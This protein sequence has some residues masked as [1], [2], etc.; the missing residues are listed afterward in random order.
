MLGANGSSICDVICRRL[1]FVLN[2][3]HSPQLLLV[4]FARMCNDLLQMVIPMSA[5]VLK[6]PYSKQSFVHLLCGGLSHAWQSTPMP[7]HEACL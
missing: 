5:V 3:Q 1:Q 7:Q 6:C 4:V 2:S